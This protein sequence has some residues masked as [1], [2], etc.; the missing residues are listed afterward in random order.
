MEALDR[1]RLLTDRSAYISFLEVQLERATAACLTTQGFSDRIEQVQKQ[2]NGMEDRIVNVSRLVKTTQ[3]VADETAEG[4]DAV[5]ARLE[6]QSRG[7]KS[8]VDELEI[9][10]QRLE[11]TGMVEALQPV[12]RRIQSSERT[13]EVLLDRVEHIKAE[14][15]RAVDTG[16]GG[17]PEAAAT[18]HRWRNELDLSVQEASR[19]VEE[20]HKE[21]ETWR[22]TFER[23]IRDS[24]WQAERTANRL[25]DDALARVEG[26]T[27][28][29]DSLAASLQQGEQNW[30]DASTRLEQL[31]TEISAARSRVASAAADA[32]S[33]RAASA[34]RGG[35][36]RRWSRSRIVSRRRSRRIC[37]G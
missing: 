25:A 9:R 37:G 29:I 5:K 11:G 22:Q 15:A 16:A 33:A 17:F 28:R 10:L 18:I 32:A 6:E 2:M 12:E 35:G 13:I 19:R 4:F 20:K 34:R 31:N 24:V 8:R 7:T 1:S 30:R 21:L 23:D 27:N 26:C 3:S 36:P 14:V